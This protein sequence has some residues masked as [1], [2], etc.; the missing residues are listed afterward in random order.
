MRLTLVSDGSPAEPV[1][2]DAAVGDTVEDLLRLLVQDGRAAA[3]ARIVVDGAALRPGHPLGAPPLLDGAIV[4]ITLSDNRSRPSNSS[5][6]ASPIRLEVVGGPDAGATLPLTPGR[7]RI[8]R[9]DDCHLAIADPHLSRVHA[10]IDVD[11]RGLSL[12]DV[13]STNGVQRI[14]ADG[15]LTAFASGALTVGDRLRIGTSTLAVRAGA[16]R[17][18]AGRPRGDGTVEVTRTSEAGSTWAPVT[19]TRPAAPAEQSRPRFPWVQVLLPL[20]ICVILAWL[21]GPQ[22]LVFAL[23]GPLLAGGTAISDRFG[24]RRRGREEQA[25][26]RAALAAH[27]AALRDAIAAE[28]THLLATHPDPATIVSVATTPTTRLWERT[29]TASSGLVVRLGTSA[30]RSTSREQSATGATEAQC[31]VLPEAPLT[32]DLSVVGSVGVGG[33]ADLVSRSATWVIVQLATLVAPGS[34][35]IHVVGEDE[36]WMG[37]LPHASTEAEDI[38]ATLHARLEAA[39]DRPVLASSRPVPTLLVITDPGLVAATP[40]LA[41]LVTDGPA[42]GVH[43]LVL[44]RTAQGLPA[45]LGATFVASADPEECRLDV[46]D[47]RPAAMGGPIALDGIDR[48]AAESIARALAP[49]RV[50]GTSAGAALPVRVAL[51]D[52]HDDP[53]PA[54]IAARWQQRSG[55][56]AVVGVDDSGPMILDLRRDGPHALIGGTTGAGKSEL[57]RAV[58][59]GLALG[60]AP[61]DLSFVLVDYKG[62][63][64]FGDLAG[65]PHVA[66]LVTDLDADLVERALVSLTAELRRRE[67]VIAATGAPDLDAHLR[68]GGDRLPRLVIVVDELRALVDELPHFVQGLVRIASLGRS[69]GVHLVLATQRP[70]GVVSA[71]I[72]A[73]VN[74]R[75]ALRVRDRVD[76]EAIVGTPHAAALPA[77]A[78]GRAI[79]A[80]AGAET[81]FQS[82]LVT[83]DE[84][85]E[86]PLSI[87][88][89]SWTLV[90][91]PRP[92][93][94]RRRP[95]LAE[96]IGEA[97][98]LGGHSA[99]GSPWLPPLST[100]VEWTPDDLAA[101]VTF[102]VTDHPSAQRIDTLSWRPESEGHLAV[103]G[104]P[105]SGRTTT[106]TTLIGAVLSGDE[107]WHVH[108]LHS[109]GELLGLDQA[110]AVGSI[111][112]L[113]DR[114]LLGRFVDRLAS[115]V[116]RR[117]AEGPGASWPR[118]LLAIDGWD[119]LAGSLTDLSGHELVE[120]LLAVLRDGPAVGMHAVATGGRSLVQGRT[121]ERFSR[122][123]ALGTIDPAEA[124]HLGLAAGPSGQL[125]PGRGV[126]VRDGAL[127]QVARHSTGVD[128]GDDVRAVVALDRRRPRLDRGPGPFRVTT[129]PTHVSAAQ[130]AEH[131]LAIGLDADREPVGFDPGDLHVLVAGPRR[132]GRSTALRALARAW[133]AQG[134]PVLLVSGTTTANLPSVPPDHTDA[135]VARLRA[136]PETALLVDDIDHHTDGPL[137]TLV[138]EAVASA[139]R[140]GAPVAVSADSGALATAFR[141]SAIQIAARRTGLLLQPR[142]AADGDL[143]GIRIRG[144]RDTRPGRGFLIRDGVA[145]SV[146]IA[147]DEGAQSGSP[148]GSAGAT[149][150]GAARS[151]ATTDMIARS[152]SDMATAVRSA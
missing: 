84:C 59:G 113:H 108:V 97:A 66:A 38:V 98:V 114:D 80:V 79:A 104:A 93:R 24:A 90:S 133:A 23:L 107:P 65:L 150:P 9:G 51:T 56:V 139:A 147:T 8:G 29:G 28:R 63:A 140:R 46:V 144:S 10:E 44:D 53:A 12:T 78:P 126:D 148:S 77:T 30:V 57:L 15:R 149:G 137:E 3:S 125:P 54:D 42:N 91:P 96:L 58:V 106:L 22:M 128:V 141:G 127:C 55:P 4:R 102:G 13:S 112:S 130:L 146:Q 43:A 101:G 48:S 152:P 67:Q 17:P 95:A 71:D 117:R 45:G 27:D 72:A 103:L 26:H 143:L 64:A 145:H 69:L 134:H 2:V 85:P 115:E 74:L 52:L 18:L 138:L 36:G 120:R 1:T 122:R 33:D 39:R 11:A 89:P 16:G 87:T 49:L 50:A 94:A 68:R 116:E 73:N 118:I 136:A 76:S 110:R 86:P 34:L 6:T 119:V 20:P 47:D 41:E 135:I 111:V 105:R 7:H 61:E 14:G 21:W 151:A 25:Q 100:Q 132:S 142:S 88:G 92:P 99:A 81:T 82:A 121:G 5:S 40:G 19:L 83:P 62:G 60:S 131:P 35:Q 31:L 32:V 37:L 123:V 109:T 70:A 129:V 75:I 124:L